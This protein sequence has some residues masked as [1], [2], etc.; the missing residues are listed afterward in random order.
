[1]NDIILISYYMVGLFQDRLKN[2]NTAHLTCLLYLL[3]GYYMSI[4]DEDKL[5]VEDFKIDMSRNIFK[6]VR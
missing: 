3:E 2:I 1:M 4:Y 5:F 6:C